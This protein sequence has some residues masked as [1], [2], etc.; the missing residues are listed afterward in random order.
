MIVYGE[1]T[2]WKTEEVVWNEHLMHTRM[3]YMH[4]SGELVLSVS[5]GHHQRSPTIDE[6]DT[7][8]ETL[9]SLRIQV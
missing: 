7:L 1:D 9:Q 6:I 8:I 3:Y 4:M 5:D 2:E